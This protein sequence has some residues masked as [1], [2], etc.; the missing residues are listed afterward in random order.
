MNEQNNSRVNEQ[1][2]RNLPNSFLLFVWRLYYKFLGLN[3]K[4]SSIIFPNAKILRHLKNINTDKFF[5]LITGKIYKHKGKV[6][7]VNIY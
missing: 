7:K 5:F 3:V 6:A 2:R 1:L 4:E